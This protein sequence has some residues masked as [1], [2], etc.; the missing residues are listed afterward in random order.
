MGGHIGQRWCTAARV[1]P[2]P[3]MRFPS[4]SQ[5]TDCQGQQHVGR[6]RRGTHRGASVGQN[7]DADLSLAAST[8]SGPLPD[9]GSVNGQGAEGARKARHSIRTYMQLLRAHA[10]R[11]SRRPHDTTGYA[12]VGSNVIQL[13]SRGTPLHA[14]RSAPQSAYRL[15]RRCLVGAYFVP[16][17]F[18]PSPDRHPPPPARGA[19]PLSVATTPLSA[20]TPSPL[21]LHLL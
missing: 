3:P 2:V 16:S 1:H 8:G 11:F 18:P 7:R 12:L 15:A 9:R 17:S 13:R 10:E 21:P 20:A 14:G 4:Q 19:A 5:A 6:K